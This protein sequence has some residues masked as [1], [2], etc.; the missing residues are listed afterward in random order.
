MGLVA[1]GIMGY[2]TNII[3]AFLIRTAEKEK[4]NKK[5]RDV[6]HDHHNILSQKKR[7]VK[8]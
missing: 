4:P 2:L 6:F 8:K 1:Y 7:P 5:K 3:R